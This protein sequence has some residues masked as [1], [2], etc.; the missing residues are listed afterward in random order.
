[1]STGF[2]DLSSVL[3]IAVGAGLRIQNITKKVKSVMT[4][5]VYIVFFLPLVLISR[6]LLFKFCYVRSESLNSDIVYPI[7]PPSDTLLPV[8]DLAPL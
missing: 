2:S 7:N 8:T 5:A 4:H 1:M 3:M 6:I